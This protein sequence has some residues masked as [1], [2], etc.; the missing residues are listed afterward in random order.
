MEEAALKALVEVFQNLHGVTE[1][2]YC[3]M[4][5]ELRVLEQA[6]ASEHF[7]ALKTLLMKAFGNKE[8]PECMAVVD[9]YVKEG[10]ERLKKILVT[11]N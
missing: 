8:S 3:H 10:S 7:S 2:A 6:I 1:Q 4:M 9:N 5:V 11:L